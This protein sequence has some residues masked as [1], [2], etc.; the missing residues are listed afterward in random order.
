MVWSSWI[1]TLGLH[2]TTVCVFAYIQETYGGYCD[3]IGGNKGSVTSCYYMYTTLERH[4]SYI[5]FIRLNKV[6]DMA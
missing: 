3:R 2:S 6:T 1:F 4:V 5:V